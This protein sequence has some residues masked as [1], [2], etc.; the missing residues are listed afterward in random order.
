M[1][2]YYILGILGG[3]D[4]NLQLGCNHTQVRLVKGNITHQSIFRLLHDRLGY[5]NRVAGIRGRTGS[6]QSGLCP[7]G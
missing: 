4:V 3:E 2:L 7:L 6:F 1:V 5:V